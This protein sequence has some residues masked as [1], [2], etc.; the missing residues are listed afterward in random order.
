MKQM[1]SFTNTFSRRG[2]LSA[3]G[4]MGLAVM[5]VALA[6]KPRGETDVTA[7]RPKRAGPNESK[8]SDGGTTYTCPMHPEVVADKPGRCPKC[9]MKLVPKSNGSTDS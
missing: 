9:G 4:T 1:R 3:L 5:P 7:R 6:S 8:L 2:I